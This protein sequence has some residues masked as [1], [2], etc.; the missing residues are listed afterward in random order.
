MSNWN[1][2]DPNT[3]VELAPSAGPAEA[4]SASKWW[5]VLLIGLPVIAVVALA[6]VIVSA[7]DD[8]GE[9][10]D[11]TADTAATIGP[12]TTAG[13][14]EDTPATT[15]DPSAS[16]APTTTAD[17]AS[18]TIETTVPPATEAPATTAAPTTPGPIPTTSVI[19]PTV[20]PTTSLPAPTTVLPGLVITD[21]IVSP[22]KDDGEPVSG[23]V[24]LE[25]G[26]VPVFPS[27]TNRVCLFWTVAGMPEG[28]ANG[29]LWTH[30]GEVVQ[31]L[32]DTELPWDRPPNDDVDWCVPGTPSGIEA[33]EHRVEY[34]VAGISQFAADF[35]VRG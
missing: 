9:S 27:W 28:V 2:P 30:E 19:A 5:W 4:R 12:G 7:S 34:F 15:L 35:I 11:D 25:P 24:P 18:T 29:I 3:K 33:G 23:A 31:A 8:D 20:P 22:G 13:D 10:G 16:A 32:E 6:A 26:K 17:D 21:V 14:V 1:P